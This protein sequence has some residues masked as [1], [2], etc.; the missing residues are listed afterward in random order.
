MTVTRFAP[1]PTGFLHVGNA[2]TALLNWL[3]ARQAGGRFLLRLDDTDAARSEE[4]FAEAIRGDLAWLGLGWDAE[5]RQSDRLERYAA[6][7]E[8]L[9]A[10]GR[11]Y[12]CFETP[13][14]LEVRRRIQLGAGKPPVY[15]RAAL[16]L[17]EAEKARLR[18]AR[19]AHWRSR[20][21]SRLRC[22]CFS[23]STRNGCRRSSRSAWLAS[24]CSE[25]CKRV[26]A[27]SRRRI[28]ASSVVC[29]ASRS[30]RCGS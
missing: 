14:E 10:A 16:R 20:R 24:D 6:A 29:S 9:R 12:E 4:R 8:R 5:A 13:Q 27:A 19:P 25:S 11:L 15:D 18:G 21:A 26:R 30:R 22:C 28:S 3:F 2:R 17:T 23:A 1:S 7:A